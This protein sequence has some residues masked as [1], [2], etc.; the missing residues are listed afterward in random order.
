MMC[1]NRNYRQSCSIFGGNTLRSYHHGSPHTSER[2]NPKYT[3][4]PT[5]PSSATPWVR[6]TPY[7]VSICLVSTDS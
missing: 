7:Y 4:S 5:Y 1:S 2:I 3:H 6:S